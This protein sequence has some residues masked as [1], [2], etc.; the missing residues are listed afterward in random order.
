VSSPKT[1]RWSLLYRASSQEEALRERDA[2]LTLAEQSAGIGVWDIDLRTSTARA[3]PQ[4][5]RIMGLEPTTEPVPMERIRALRHPEDRE[6][7]VEGFRRAL[8]SGT[9]AYEM[10]YRIIRPDGAVRWIFGRGRVVRDAG[11]RPVRYS[12]VDMDVTERKET[13]AALAA[14]KEALE[15]A[16]EALEERVRERTAQL[17]AEAR[18]RAEAEARLHQAQKMEA[19][20]QL[21]GGVAHDFNNLLTVIMGGLETIGRQLEAM[22]ADVRPAR[23]ERARD[24]AM[25]GAQ[26]AATLTKRLLAFSRR[27]PLEPKPVDIR[28]LISGLTEL[29]ERTLGEQIR[30]ETVLAAGTWPAMVDV[31]QLENAILNLAVNARDAMPEGGKLTIETSNTSLDPSYVQQFSEPIPPGQ[32]VM[33][34]VSDTGSGMD[35]ETVDRVFEPFFTTKEAGKGTG[36]GLSQ[37][38]GFLRQSGGHVRIYSEVGVGTSVKI[39]LPRLAG[40]AVQDTAPA[41]RPDLR[42]LRG[43]ETVLFVEDH[44]DLRGYGA[45]ILRELGYEVLTAGDG[46]QALDL[47][48]SAPKVELLFTDVVLAGGMNGR[49]LAEQALR[50]RPDLKVLFTTG[51][52]RNAIVHNGTLDPGVNLLP[53]PFSFE[54]L[55]LKVRTVLDA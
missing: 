7:V 20:G 43:T 26:R 34:A 40:M 10:E 21:T 8:E 2:I 38:Y 3:T 22:P 47:L 17:E 13:A 25:Q 23:M 46:G 4:F 45:G 29:L 41:V 32:Y 18:R 27:Q 30:L 52:T 14:A 24:M 5:Y 35:A 33:I 9:D 6:R 48:S 50:L 39:Y 28:R 37:V 36:L 42:L 31:S 53:K 11:G 15:R 12:G 1:S 51:Y 49:Q 44:E 19:V 16:N 55:A 54:E